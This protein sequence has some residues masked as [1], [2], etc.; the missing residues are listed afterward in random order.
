[1]KRIFASAISVLTGIAIISTT[2]LAQPP[3]GVARSNTDFQQSQERSVTEPTNTVLP[4]SDPA[5]TKNWILDEALSDEFNEPQLDTEKW[6]PIPYTWA[7]AWRWQDDNVSLSDGKLHLMARHD[8]NDLIDESPNGWNSHN[9][10]DGDSVNGEYV[11]S[12]YGSRSGKSALVYGN[13]FPIWVRTDTV[14]RN[15]DPDKTYSF[16]AYVKKT[17]NQ[18]VSKMYAVDPSDKAI[19][20]G[21]KTMDFAENDDFV[22]YTLS[23]I[24]PG[25]G[26]MCKI[27]FEVKADPYAM[28][29]IDDVNF[30]EEGGTTNLAPNPGFEDVTDMNYSSGGIISRQSMK[31]GYM[32]TR[33]KGAPALP[34]AC[35]AIWLLGRTENWGTEIDVLEIGQTQTVNELDFAIHTF[36]TPSS[37]QVP[38]QDK[39]PHGSAGIWGSQNPFNPSRE[40]HTYGLEWGPGY[41]NFYVDGKLKGRFYSGSAGPVQSDTVWQQVSTTHASNMDAIPQNL[42]LSLGLRPPYRDGNMEDFHTVFDVDYVRVWRSNNVTATGNIKEVNTKEGNLVVPYGTTQDELEARLDTSV[43]VMLNQ[44]SSLSDQ[45]DI[46]VEWDT[47]GFDGNAEGTIYTLEGQ[48]VNLP[49]G[50]TNTDHINAKLNVYIQAKPYRIDREELQK[51]VNRVYHE[52]EYKAAS[53]QN[54]LLKKREAQ[55]VLD[56]TD[57]ADREIIE[58]YENLKTAIQNLEFLPDLNGLIKQEYFAGNY[59]PQSWWRYTQALEA[60]KKVLADPEA[61]GSEIEKAYARLKEAIDALEA[62]PMGENLLLGKTPVSNTAIGNNKQAATDGSADTDIG[63]GPSTD[64]TVYTTVNAGVESGGSDNGYSK[65]EGAYLQYDFGGEKAVKQVEINRFWYLTDFRSVTWKDCMVQLSTTP[66]FTADTTTTIFGKADVVMES[67]TDISGNLRKTPQIISLNEPVTARY[68]RVYGKG[69]KGGWGGYSA[70][71]SYSE[72]QAFEA[73]EVNSYGITGRVTG[74]TGEGAGDVT[75]KLYKGSDISTASPSNAVKTDEEGVYGF[76]DL[77]D[78]VYSVELPAKNGYKQEVKTVEINGKNAG[79]VDFQLVKAAEEQADRKLKVKTLPAK[80][81]YWIGQQL[82]LTGLEVFIYKDGVEERQ[83]EDGEYTVG[84]LDTSK[85]GIQKI[86]VT[87][88]DRSADE[89]VEYETWFTVTVYEEKLNQSIKV[90][91][92]P[93]QLVY[94]TGD[95]INPEGLEVRG[96]N[97][98]DEKVTVLKEGDYILEYDTSK[99]GTTTVTVVCS[100]ESGG[101]PAVELKDF[102][103]IRVFDGNESSRIV[104]QIKVTQ[105]PYKLTYEPE[106]EFDPEGMIVEK[107]V[108]VLA[109]SSNATYTER[110]PLEALEVEKPDLSK[111][112]NR[113]VKVLYYGEDKDGEEVVFS[114]SFSVKVSKDK[115]TVITGTLYAIQKELEQALQYREYLTDSEK[116]A[117]FSQAIEDAGECLEAHGKDGRI[118]DKMYSKLLFLDRMLTETYPDI[119]V[120]VNADNILKNVNA[121]GLI[122]SADL[123]MGQSQLLCLDIEKTTAEEAISEIAGELDHLLAVDISMITNEEEIQSVLPVRLRMQIPE[124]M[125][126]KQ[127]VI[128]QYHNGEWSAITPA[129]KGNQM[130]FLITDLSLFVIGNRKDRITPPVTDNSDS[131]VWEP[132]NTIPGIWKKD[133]T[134]W[135]YQKNSGGYITS[136]W[137][138]IDGLW[139]C[140]DEAGYMITD[141]VFDNGIWYFMN[142]DGSMAVSRWVLWGDQ[143]YYLGWNGAMAV[144][145][146]T[147]DGYV[148]NRNG[149]WVE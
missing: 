146:V 117:A 104:E 57:A 137:A 3:E 50:V 133:D 16:T 107:T 132:A 74:E 31:Y 11:T 8:E 20:I 127:L 86:S 108:K 131:S 118:S 76:W 63:W 5:N 149:A 29:I 62:V 141:W 109:L 100:I 81:K 14:I 52:K 83:L 10:Y 135:W 78:G 69:H 59:T 70:R 82:D 119:K 80:T 110:V 64:K 22:A 125:S 40:Y 15:L 21:G 84:K 37:V 73:V 13:F 79:A 134:G 144:N 1:M 65:W 102:F 12:L 53:W 49:A 120:A 116:Q 128:Y 60:A 126:K 92:K 129:V 71:M 41:Q 9:M 95:E 138:Q 33:A 103:D 114:D 36:K 19:P 88:T 61:A 25:S 38:E 2:T 35:S 68:L 6:Q 140:F 67:D 30:Q 136:S 113:K 97:L 45:R 75:V 101:V 142:P 47:S 34:G 44:A 28:T 32:E 147:P 55:A 85:P 91:K 58:A 148:V 105:K 23:G 130:S 66:D 143:W 99:A 124:G 17:G 90:V 115:E 121:Q 18:P 24:T 51:L 27:G 77:L 54:Y 43:A 56:K 93:D 89:P 26:G 4:G 123:S 112:G 139:Y 72:I 39:N 94:T 106:E 46:D 48:L 42:L 87:Y 96:L 7:G 111:T 98:T 145:T 122:L